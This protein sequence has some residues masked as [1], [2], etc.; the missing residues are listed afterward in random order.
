MPKLVVSFGDKVIN[1]YILDSKPVLTIGR[2]PGN[3]VVIK[4]PTVSR[5]H[6]R[7][8]F[9]EGKY[10]LTDLGSMNGTFVNKVRLS[11]R[12]LEHGDVVTI[13]KHNLA[14]LLTDDELLPLNVL[15]NAV[16]EFRQDTGT[17]MRMAKSAKAGSPILFNKAVTGATGVLLFLAGGN[18]EIT[19]T[20]E[21][22]NIGKDL[23]CDIVVRGLFIGKIACTINRSPDGYLLTYVGGPSKPKVDGEFVKGSK[24][25][26]EYDIIEIGSVVLQFLLR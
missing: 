13:G 26:K 8:E 9:Q 5:K 15:E 21:S 3:D 19:L 16:K 1:E 7:I 22:I 2:M 6:A 10:L 4:D 25:L 20:D 11:S 14:F 23:A 12:S 18:G 24:M 17:D